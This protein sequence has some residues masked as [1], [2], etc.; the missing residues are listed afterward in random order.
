MGIGKFVG[1][2]VNQRLNDRR[3][4]IDIV[5]DGLM[6]DFHVMDIVHDGGRF[7]QRKGVVDVVGKHKP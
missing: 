1:V 4:G 3:N 7:P 2:M 6:R 5:G